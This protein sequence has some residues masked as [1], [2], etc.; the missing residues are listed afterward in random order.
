MQYISTQSR[1]RD[2]HWYRIANY[3][4]LMSMKEVTISRLYNLHKKRTL[5]YGLAG[6][7]ET[8]LRC[9]ICIRS[10]R[11]LTSDGNISIGCITCIR[12]VR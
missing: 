7:R 9:L 4:D 2:Y 11:S 12:S 3:I 1:M 5:D 10:V 6:V 8:Y